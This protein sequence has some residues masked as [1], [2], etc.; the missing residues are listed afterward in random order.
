MKKLLA[1]LLCALLVV[2]MVACNTPENT[3]TENDDKTTTEAKADATTE[4]KADETTEAKDEETT[5][6]KAETTETKTEATTEEKVE[7]T[8]APAP[9]KEVTEGTL[10]FDFNTASVDNSETKGY[11]WDKDT[12]TLT[13]CGINLASDNGVGIEIACTATVV[14]ADG[15][16]NAIVVTGQKD[17]GS[18]GI[19]ATDNL[20]FK[21]AGVLNITAGDYEAELVDTGIT[22][23]G[24]CAKNKTVELDGATLNIVCGTV[25]DNL[26]NLRNVQ[27]IRCQD[28][29]VKSGALDIKTGDCFT[30]TKGA[31]LD[32]IYATGAYNQVGGD[33]KIFIGYCHIIGD[34]LFR[35]NLGICADGS[36]A[37]SGGSIEVQATLQD[38]GKAI[39]APKYDFGRGIIKAGASER[40][41]DK[42]YTGQLYLKVTFA[43]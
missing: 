13:L 15:T 10:K 22:A 7:I 36:F 24:I 17:L 42:D 38:I 39:L 37:I 43:E 11:K 12:L 19:L 5:E 4:A 32:G 21:G 27:G 1:L 18:H 9:G 2:A 26:A 3:E 16:E 35:E 33:V 31:F 6:A 41:N 34:E 14:V 25:G 30:T 28:L 20:T 40:G 29:N 23:Y 8:E